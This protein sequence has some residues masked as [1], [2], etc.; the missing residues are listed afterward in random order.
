MAQKAWLISLAPQLT[1]VRLVV[2]QT[3]FSVAAIEPNE[4]PRES[5]A[6]I[7]HAYNTYA[8]CGGHLL[9]EELQLQQRRR[10]SAEDRLCAVKDAEPTGS[11]SDE[12]EEQRRGTPDGEEDPTADSGGAGVIR[13]TTT[14][15][16]ESSSSWSCADDTAHSALDNSRG[17]TDDGLVMHPIGE[18]IGEHNFVDFFCVQSSVE[19]SRDIL[20]PVLLN[21]SD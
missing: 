18:T 12:D 7:H 1:S 8:L 10:A 16:S 5:A 9:Q 15:S 21:N 13:A 2:V 6:L 3:S 11:P 20:F 17:S 19:I 14:G 4:P